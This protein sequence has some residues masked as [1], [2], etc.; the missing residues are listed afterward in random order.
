V[1]WGNGIGPDPRWQ[2]DNRNSVPSTN[3]RIKS[4]TIGDKADY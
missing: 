2:L 1:E 4:G 3:P